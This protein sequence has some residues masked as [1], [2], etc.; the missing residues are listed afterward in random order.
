MIKVYITYMRVVFSEETIQD[1]FLFSDPHE[2]QCKPGSTF[3][4]HVCT[5]VWVWLNVF[6]MSVWDSLK[7]ASL[8]QHLVHFTIVV[9]VRPLN[10]HLRICRHSGLNTTGKWGTR[11]PLLSSNHSSPSPKVD[12]MSNLLVPTNHVRDMCLLVVVL[13]M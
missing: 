2:K 4:G 1:D 6:T 10:L 11:T 8:T 3:I 9:Q 13:N 12:L 7:Q 5:Y